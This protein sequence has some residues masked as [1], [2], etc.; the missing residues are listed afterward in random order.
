MSKQLMYV[1]RNPTFVS[2][3]S[4]LCLWPL[5]SLSLSVFLR[6][7]F[8][9]A[10][11][12]VS[13]VSLSLSGSVSLSICVS[14]SPPPSFFVSLSLSLAAFSVAFSSVASADVASFVLF[15]LPSP[16]KPSKTLNPKPWGLSGF[17]VEGAGPGLL[18][19]ER[20]RG[21][22]HRPRLWAVG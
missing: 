4:C 6:L 20:L 1:H 10:S 16:S 7:F 22:E 8:T 19:G 11:V 3:P 12:S 5:L 18:G 13:S 21:D 2:V 17:L 14:L 15:T 9:L